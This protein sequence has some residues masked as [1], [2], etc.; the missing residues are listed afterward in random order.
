VLGVA[1]TILFLCLAPY[2]ALGDWVIM[3]AVSLAIAA[4][5]E[6]CGATA[7]EGPGP[8]I[9]LNVG[10]KEF[11]YSLLGIEEYNPKG[12][13]Y[14]HM[15]PGEQE[16]EMLLNIVGFCAALFGTFFAFLLG[17]TELLKNLVL[18]AKLKLVQMLEVGGIVIGVIALIMA[19]A[20]FL[21]PVFDTAA[22]ETLALILAVVSLLLFFGGLVWEGKVKMEK[23]D[24]KDWIGLSFCVTGFTIALG[25]LLVRTG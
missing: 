6:A 12:N 24:K 3:G 11:L 13:R 15:N 17:G 7:I 25:D 21:A 16:V 19:S 23:L 5:V 10:L 22:M 20:G 8:T 2:T 18:G 9:D 1:I 14:L 4:F